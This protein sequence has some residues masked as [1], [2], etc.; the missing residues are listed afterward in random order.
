[1]PLLPPFSADALEAIAKVL[2]GTSDGL[3]GSD[4]AHILPEGRF[5]DT[6]LTVTKWKRLFNVPVHAQ[7]AAQHGSM[8]VGIIHKAMKPARW[9][10]R[11]AECPTMRSNLNEALHRPGGEL[12]ENGGVREVDAARTLSEAEMRAVQ[13]RGDLV[14]LR[15]VAFNFTHVSFTRT[16][17]GRR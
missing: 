7:N 14:A 8:V 10:G 11:S 17:V 3:K 4:T 1:M 9:R 15:R 16:A 13:L 6:D 12:G 2:A 5:Q